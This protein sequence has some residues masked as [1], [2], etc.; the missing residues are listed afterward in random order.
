MDQV[1]IAPAKRTL[2]GK[3]LGTVIINLQ[4]TVCDPGATLRIFAECDELFE[5]LL[6]HLSLASDPYIAG[7]KSVETRVLVPYDR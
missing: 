3:S 4:Q 5:K 1:A 7:P 6:T 2:T